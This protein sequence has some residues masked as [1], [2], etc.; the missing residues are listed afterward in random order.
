[1][2]FLKK[3]KRETIPEYGKIVCAWCKIDMGAKPEIKPGLISH[4]I[5][6]QCFEIEY[7]RL[8]NDKHDPPQ[9]GRKSGKGR[10]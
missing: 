5:C 2:E 9:A 1:M 8:T 6:P 10:G 4:G 7:E 3:R